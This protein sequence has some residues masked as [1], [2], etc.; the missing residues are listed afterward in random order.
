M[1]DYD[2]DDLDAM[3]G[4]RRYYGW[5]LD[6]FRP[7]LGGRGIDVGAGSGTISRLVLPFLDRLDLLEPS[8]NLAA[9]L[10]QDF[11]GDPRVSVFAGTLGPDT[12]SIPDG[13][14]DTAIM[15]NVLEHFKDDAAALNEVRRLLRPGGHLLIFVPA[16]KFL[17]SEHD[18]YIGHYR[19]YHL[20]ELRDLVRGAGFEVVFSRYFDLLGVLPWWLINTIGGKVTMEPGMAN[21]YD[22]LGVPVTRAMENLFPP[23]LG[24]NIVLVAR[25]P[26]A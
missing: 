2:A 21:L 1:N 3:R 10:K 4:A 7:Y 8:P 5:I 13:D 11:T 22:R 23:P 20:T 16:L 25:R 17:F 14:R 9:K 24:K 19:R 18:R 6:H 26:Q 15:V 12:E